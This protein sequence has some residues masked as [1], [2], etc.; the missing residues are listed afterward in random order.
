MVVRLVHPRIR[1]GQ[2]SNATSRNYLVAS[3]TYNMSYTCTTTHAHQMCRV[4]FGQ[5]KGGGQGGG[6][7][8]PQSVL[9][10]DGCQTPFEGFHL[11]VLKK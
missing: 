11:Q 1:P 10:S 4:P 7:V 3:K 8:Q 2:L 6:L 5:C 9:L